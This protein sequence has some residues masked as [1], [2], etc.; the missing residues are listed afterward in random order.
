ML[1]TFQ[2]DV[3]QTI[4][5]MNI[6]LFEVHDWFYG[7]CNDWYFLQNLKDFTAMV[8]VQRFKGHTFDRIFQDDTDGNTAMVKI[9]CFFFD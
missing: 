5:T 1:A 7:P 8:L 2:I 6:G 3:V 9:S 4:E